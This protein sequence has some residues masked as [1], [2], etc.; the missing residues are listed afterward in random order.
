M[1]EMIE[2]GKFCVVTND[3][4]VEHGIAKDDIVYVAGDLFVPQSEEDIYLMRRIYLCARME[5]DNIKAE[6]G[7]F[8]IDGTSLQ[9]VD[10]FT[11]TRLDKQRALDF[12]K[13][14][15]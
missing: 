6:G 5:G 15:S 7:A 3:N 10:E 4:L 1:K 9:H 13:L 8:T 14:E 12:G 2:V 11:Q